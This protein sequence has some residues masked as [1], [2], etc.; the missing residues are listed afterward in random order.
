MWIWQMSRSWAAARDEV[1]QAWPWKQLEARSPVSS[2]LCLLLWPQPGSADGVGKKDSLLA[3]LRG[4]GHR[5][6]VL[7]PPPSR[8]PSLASCSQGPQVG[9]GPEVAHPWAGSPWS[10]LPLLAPGDTSGLH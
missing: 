3:G 8:S 4:Q 9:Q 10:R 7:C 2:T 1:W 6:P 5:E